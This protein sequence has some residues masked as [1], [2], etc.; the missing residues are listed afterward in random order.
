MN[1]SLPEAV[2]RVILKLL[3][4]N[5]AHRYG[6][7]HEARS[8][9]MEA[10][11]LGEPTVPRE[12]PLPRLPRGMFVGHQRV[13]DAIGNLLMGWD[14]ENGVMVCIQGDRGRGKTRLLEELGI[15]IALK[16][17]WTAES[18]SGV[19]GE[20]GSTLFGRTSPPGSDG[21]TVPP[22]SLRERAI[23]AAE[24]CR[25]S[26]TS[27]VLLLDDLDRIPPESI[28][29]LRDLLGDL[30]CLPLFVLAT[31]TG[32]LPFSS[33]PGQ[34]AGF[35]L[36]PLSQP[37]TLGLLTSILPSLRELPELAEWVQR[38]SDGNP[39]EITEI[40]E[41]LR[42]RGDLR[43]GREGWELKPTTLTEERFP[44]AGQPSAA[45]T[46]GQLG[47]DEQELARVAS[48]LGE[49]FRSQVLKAIVDWPDGRFFE[50][51]R[52]L[53]E[54]AI[55][56]RSGTA[57]T[58]Y[59]FQ[60]PSLF[61]CLR[62]GV[63]EDVAPELHRRIAEALLALVLPGQKPSSVQIAGHFLASDAP[64]RA[65]PYLPGMGME[66]GSIDAPTAADLVRRF[67]KRARESVSL[68]ERCQL[69][70]LLGDLE[71]GS[72]DHRAAL[73][74]YQEVLELG[75][76]G[77]DRARVLRKT[78]SAK[79][80]VGDIAGSIK[81][82][83]EVLALSGVEASLDRIQALLD[84]SWAHLDQGH[85]GLALELCT[86]A[87]GIAS[88]NGWARET[89]RA[90]L[91]EATIRWRSG[92]LDQA[93]RLAEE[94]RRLFSAGNDEQLLQA[95][96]GHLG[97]LHGERG[98]PSRAQAWHQKALFLAEKRKDLFGLAQVCNNL[99]LVE[100]ES[101][102]L[103]AAID[104]FRKGLGIVRR[105]G[106][107]VGEGHLLI[108]LGLAYE[109]NGE[110]MR[111][112]AHHVAA[113]T[114]WERLGDPSQIALCHHNLGQL[115]LA[116]GLLEEAAGHLQHALLVRRGLG[117]RLNLARTHL[118]LTRL[119]ICR[120]EWGGAK[121]ELRSAFRL[122]RGDRNPGWRSLLL[123]ARAEMLAGTGHLGKARNTLTRAVML[124]HEA[125]NLLE[126]SAAQS[127]LALVALRAGDSEDALA[128]A[129]EAMQSARAAGGQPELARA[130]LARSE[131]Q[132][133][134]AASQPARNVSGT[135]EHLVAQLRE[136]R[137]IASRLGAQGELQRA[138]A[139]QEEL[140]GL[141]CVSGSG[142]G[143]AG[144]EHLATLR[145]AADLVA[146]CGEGADVYR[147]VL[148][149]AI[150]EV[151]AERGALFL[152]DGR[153]RPVEMVA[154]CGI[155]RRTLDDSSRLSRSVLKQVGEGGKPLVSIDAQ[156]DH[157]LKQRQSVIVNRIRSLLCVPLLHGGRVTG[158]LYLDS[159]GTRTPFLKRDEDFLM[160]LGSLLA[161][162][163][164]AGRLSRLLQDEN[165]A[166]RGEAVRT[167]GA[168]EIVGE[169]EPMKRLYRMMAKAAATNSHVLIYGE[170]GTGKEVVG[171]AIHR[172]GA[173]RDLPF[174]PIDCGALAETLLE[175]ELFGYLKGAFTGAD[176]DKIGLFKEADKGTAFLDEICS[177]SPSVQARLLR[178][179]EEGHFRP[180]GGTKYLKADVRVICASNRDL[181]VEVEDKNFRADLYYR[182]R[183]MQIDVPPLRDRGDDILLLARH[184]LRSSAHKLG[185]RILGFDPDVMRVFME[186]P[187]PG[188]VR[189][190]E[191]CVEWAVDMA[192]KPWIMVEDI[193]PLVLEGAGEPRRL[194]LKELRRELDA[195]QI[196]VALAASGGNVSQAARLLGTNRRQLQRLLKEHQIDR[197]V[198]RPKVP[199]RGS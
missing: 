9:V 10:W 150:K 122:S 140:L 14:R 106:Q 121:E 175:G 128:H 199:E 137:E 35:H 190:L 99:G 72:G 193:D 135:R 79:E 146:P 134:R 180:L 125:K 56:R 159:R 188:N 29:S 156:T 172:G 78:A 163:I 183:V 24:S 136:A 32:L 170:N 101:R 41:T 81:D 184:F 69:T 53:E 30:S 118:L 149:L 5:P 155:D 102:S 77:S 110:W 194:S 85:Y 133:R 176:R 49:S 131:I 98:N 124:A 165:A 174:L 18:W 107:G 52:Q 57:E 166:L 143:I 26:A 97:I 20:P 169:S 111:S 187:W 127:D 58:S 87:Q 60:T 91:H 123:R 68:A 59:V 6:S 112:H 177:A 75:P 17:G 92:D 185:K 164:E 15:R 158:A 36:W 130:L 189:Q 90:L 65:Y 42:T 88:Q 7:A 51:L 103:P 147:R 19:G 152:G 129:E 138:H 171:R 186:Y 31:H 50:A 161:A 89:G 108:N 22:G 21:A 145:R 132:L 39:G 4:T 61:A 12:E 11:G 44:F 148:D 154:G 3:A 40:L 141:L 83:K 8:A 16:E 139:L 86:E 142:T 116:R 37:E 195:D 33:L 95:A 114:V 82:L 94:A 157:R 38:R 80:D 46:V 181:A 120:Q 96:Y 28:A 55:V 43:W 48:L 70:E 153:G 191:N 54:R 119:A 113:L 160:A 71:D 73:L 13:L 198:F 1:P 196:R 197:R 84:L 192:E 151:G 23:A 47:P 64:E 162:T 179:L 25:S 2:E 67:L 115:D 178:F 66:S 117:E 63:P 105:L 182:L 34:A 144:E 62:D 74:R 45:E 27:L 168:R 167:L 126:A 109:Q 104:L 76:S 173:R 100:L 93:L